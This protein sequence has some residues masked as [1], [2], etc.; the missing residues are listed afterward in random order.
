MPDQSSCHWWRNHRQ[1]LRLPTI[2]SH[3]PKFGIDDIAHHI[4]LSASISVESQD[5]CRDL[6]N[7]CKATPITN[8][9]RILQLKN[10]LR[11]LTMGSK[12]LTQ[13]LF[14]IES[15]VNLITTTKTHIAPKDIIYYT[16]NGL[17]SSYQDF[18]IALHTSLQMINLKDLYSLPCSEETMLLAEATHQE[19]NTQITL[20]ANWTE[21][22]GRSYPRNTSRGCTSSS[23]GRD[24][25]VNLECQICGKQGHSVVDCWHQRNL[26][27]SSPRTNVQ[28]MQAS[29]NPFAESEWLLDSGLSTHLANSASHLSFTSLYR[30]PNQITMGNGQIIL[31]SNEGRGPWWKTLWR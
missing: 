10:K 24:K 26:Q 7:T 21:G 4:P 8:R 15:K 6:G 30:G 17:P 5:M 29:T 31:I 18:K 2:D 16:L 3:W 12:I 28:A 22:K 20:V 27:Y 19:T 9:G 13:Y 11:N 23:R 1:Q 25:Y 14:D